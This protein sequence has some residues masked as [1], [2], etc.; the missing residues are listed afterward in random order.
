MK[1]YNHYVLGRLTQAFGFFSL[2]LMLAY[3]IN[4]SLGI[5]SNLIGDGQSTIVFFELIFLF[6]PQVVAIILPIAALAATIF[7]IN[8]MSSES[9]L[10]I[11]DA[12]GLSPF[13][14]LKPFVYFAF[15]TSI[16][17]AILSL[18]LVPISRSQMDFRTEMI[19]KDIISKLISD[20]SF[21]HPVK[22][23]TI[24]VSSVNTNGELEDIFIHDQRSKDRDL[25][26]VATRAVLVKENEKSHLILFNGLLQTL[27]I[28]SNTLS[29][30]GFESLTYK[31]A[32]LN[33]TE[34]KQMSNIDNYGIIE[35][36][37]ADQTLQKLLKKS[38]SRL[39]FEAH[40]RLLKPLHCFLYVLLSAVIMC[41]GS[42]SR[43]GLVPQIFFS[44]LIVLG[45]NILTTNGLVLLRK[46]SSN[47][48]FGYLPVILGFIIFYLLLTRARKSFFIR[49]SFFNL[50][51][52]VYE[53]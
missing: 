41:I 39:Q 27:D 33:S 46:D 49:S 16:L 51:A 14:I 47:W 38:K 45:F 22:N 18:Y 7:I 11:L 44:I 9:E 6:L 36:L 5:F 1:H 32:Q 34:E 53:A 12:A 30:I 26:Y 43:F 29:H 31:L 4:R 8:R 35:L 42:Y 24:F 25:T 3:W 23:M 28:K 20:G 10:V 50:K 21:L 15:L 37:K 52:Q 13:A 2:I 40:D 19:S 17:T 48:I